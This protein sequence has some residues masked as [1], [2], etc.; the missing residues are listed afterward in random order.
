ME[1]A[2][3]GEKHDIRTLCIPEH[4]DSDY[5]RLGC[6]QLPSLHHDTIADPTAPGRAQRSSSSAAAHSRP[7]PL[8]QMWPHQPLLGQVP[9][10][11]HEGAVSRSVK[12]LSLW[13]MGV[14]WMLPE[15]TNESTGYSAHKIRKKEKYMFKKLKQVHDLLSFHGWRPF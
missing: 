13:R 4:V 8:P 3:S 12:G 9:Q 15:T 7:L 10:A 6:L 14:V 11:L 5:Q 1:A 2:P